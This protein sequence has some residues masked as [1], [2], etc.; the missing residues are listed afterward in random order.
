M[1]LRPLIR[2]LHD[3]TPTDLQYQTMT[4]Q[5]ER[6]LQTDTSDATNFL[7][8]QKISALSSLKKVPCNGC[9]EDADCEKIEPEN[10]D[11]PSYYC[12]YLRCADI[13]MSRIGS[14]SSVWVTSVPS[15]VSPQPILSQHQPITPAVGTRDE[16][17]KES[18][19][20]SE[21]GKPSN[22]RVQRRK[23][24]KLLKKEHRQRGKQIPMKNSPTVVW[25]TSSFEWLE[26]PPSLNKN[27]QLVSTDEKLPE[28]SAGETNLATFAVIPRQ[29]RYIIHVKPLIVLDLNG[30]LCHR[31]RKNDL[32]SPKIHVENIDHSKISFRPSIG[33]VA[34]TDIIPRSDLFPFLNYLNDHFSLAVWTSATRRTALSLVNI[35]FPPNVRQRLVFVWSRN[36]C[37]LV[38]TASLESALNDDNGFGH[39]NEEADASITDVS[40]QLADNEASGHETLQA[41]DPS[42]A[43]RVKIESVKQIEACT[44]HNMVLEETSM[45]VEEK[46]NSLDDMNRFTGSNNRTTTGNDGCMEGKNIACALKSNQSIGQS[47]KSSVAQS[48]NINHDNTR[49]TKRRR[50]KTKHTSSSH[51]GLTAIKSLGKVWLEFPLWNNS[52]TLLLDDS[53][54]KCPKQF[55]GNALHPP[56]IRGTCTI[57]FDEAEN[58]DRKIS[59]DSMNQG[60]PASND[61]AIDDD[62]ANQKTQQ[63]F[64]ELLAKHW[65]KPSPFHMGND[66]KLTSASQSEESGNRSLELFLKEN[67]NVFNMGWEMSARV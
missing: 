18:L 28:V 3:S 19:T 15:A 40:N 33:H 51:E 49:N 59:G 53:P 27:S 66:A 14:S 29:P 47:T 54:E 38:K 4:I 44:Q 31:I 5:T 25:T 6:T 7:S 62:N 23:A 56:S 9:N 39:E 64:F 58:G 34:N 65:E 61:C 24:K 22:D 57:P 12:A 55:R 2:T 26:N 45:R 41:V 1:I 36:F 10:D 17:A 35:L 8:G 13:V 50:K 32:S 67:A 37:N 11:G 63:Q 48:S 43:K 30:I 52:N 46:A 20:N 42:E 60:S 16:E 21:T